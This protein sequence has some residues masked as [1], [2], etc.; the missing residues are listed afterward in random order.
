[1]VELLAGIP[2]ISIQQSVKAAEW[3]QQQT[4]LKAVFLG[5]ASGLGSPDSTKTLSAGQLEELQCPLLSTHDAR[6]PQQVYDSCIQRSVGMHIG[7]LHLLK[8]LHLR[9]RHVELCSVPRRRQG[10]KDKVGTYASARPSQSRL[11]IVCVMLC[12]TAQGPSTTTA[13]VL[14]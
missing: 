8:H 3:A 2:T 6:A 14:L 10:T 13:D 5:T 9:S 12:D 1:M 7:C 4:D 11:K